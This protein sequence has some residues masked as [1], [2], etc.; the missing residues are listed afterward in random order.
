MT[1][2]GVASA[3]SGSGVHSG[4]VEAVE[5]MLDRGLTLESQGA[6]QTQRA[7]LKDNLSRV[8]RGVLLWA[9]RQGVRLQVMQSGEEL[10]ALDALRDLKGKFEE[11]MSPETVSQLHSHLAP[12]TEKIRTEKDPERALSLR[13]QKRQELA[14]LLT[15]NPSGAAVFTPAFA[16][17][18]APGLSRLAAD[19]TETP[20]LKGMAIHHGANSAEEQ[21]Q[22]YSW[23]EALNGERLKLAREESIEERSRLLRERPE[24]LKRWE[25]Q[26]EEHPETVPLDTTL[27]TLVVP[28]AHFFPS[29]GD[30]EPLLLDRSD[31]LSIEGW[32]NGDFRGQWFF[33]EGKAN[34]L[35]RDSAVTL[36]TP[37]HELGH[38]VDMGLEK[39][40]PDFYRSL[41]PRIE[42]AHYQARLHGQAITSYAMANR[43]EYIA[44]GF[45]AYYDK[46]SELRRVD[47]ELHQLIEEMVDYCCR[48]SGAD[49]G[50]DRKLQKMWQDAVST[51]PGVLRPDVLRED[52][53][54][55]LTSL[56]DTQALSRSA[57]AAALGASR[58][59]LLTGMAEV[60]LGLVA[61]ASPP[62]QSLVDPVQKA[63]SNGLDTSG[64]V[65]LFELAYRHGLS[66]G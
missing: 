17:L 35:I 11:R 33:L 56:P 31:L 7:I 45:A 60:A 39:G 3:S 18:L 53:E 19:P 13:R 48:D 32:R 59:G 27:H 20:T 10:E 50:L 58:L 40:A 43:R 14:E 51:D 61:P 44:E 26:A 47:P 66:L 30:E 28:D 1:P 15:L 38:V 46:P 24:A 65:E 25:K 4:K 21:S 22:F 57:Q 29:K 52:F 55:Q 64:Q 63:Y 62:D 34:L 8:D 23:M 36:D 9:R 16:P 12:L 2:Q 54:Q 6:D 37:I 42:R 5:V 49:R 41:R